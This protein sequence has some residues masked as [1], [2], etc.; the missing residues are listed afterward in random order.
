MINLMPPMHL[1][2]KLILVHCNYMYEHEVEMLVLF[3]GLYSR[4]SLF[5]NGILMF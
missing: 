4:F 5:S 3:Y 1:R 2:Q